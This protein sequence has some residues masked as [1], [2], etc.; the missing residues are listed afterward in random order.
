MVP[1]KAYGPRDC[2]NEPI[3]A[4]LA[5]VIAANIDPLVARPAASSAR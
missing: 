3:S 5:F 1:T 4:A 2:C